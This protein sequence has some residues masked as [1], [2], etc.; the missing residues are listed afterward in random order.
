LIGESSCELIEDFDFGMATFLSK[1]FGEDVLLRHFFNSSFQVQCSGDSRHFFSFLNLHTTFLPTIGLAG[2]GD[3]VFVF[4]F[5]LSGDGEGVFVLGLSGDGEGVFVLGLSSDG[6]GVFVLGL[7]SDGE[8][9][10]VF[11]LG[12]SGDGEGVFVL[13]LSGDGVL[14]LLKHLFISAFQTQCS[15][16]SRHFFSFL[17]LHTIFFATMFIYICINK[18]T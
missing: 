14:V 8:G 2:A 12:L 1:F 18:K 10:F 17:N 11:V 5:G 16:D 13:G 15:G 6:E 9:V 7:S 3:G 4:V